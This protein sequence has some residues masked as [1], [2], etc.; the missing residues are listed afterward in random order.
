MRKRPARDLAVAAVA[1][2]ASW[3]AAEDWWLA[4]SQ[5]RGANARSR[6]RRAVERQITLLVEAG[7]AAHAG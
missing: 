5:Y 6:A 2:I 7:L 1:I 3:V 4:V